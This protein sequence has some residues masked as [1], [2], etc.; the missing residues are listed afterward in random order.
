MKSKT[1]FVT[2]S[3]ALVFISLMSTSTVLPQRTH[4]RGSEAVWKSG[5]L[6]IS[7]PVWAGD[8]LLK[9]GM[10]HVKHLVDRDKHWMVFNTVTL[11]AGHREG[12]MF[13]G[14]EVARLECRLGP[15]TKSIRNT[16]F[17][18]GKTAAGQ[19]L[20]QEIQIAGEKVTHI[21]LASP[22]EASGLTYNRLAH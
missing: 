22:P 18:V 15:D 1:Q 20:I 11:A 17:W 16:K 10:Y 9:T 8:V 7:K 2:V 19:P 4:D 5:M 3:L 6:R 14:K 13:E 12:S 21:L